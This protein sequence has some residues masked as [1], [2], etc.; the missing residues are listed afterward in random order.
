MFQE[1]SG[2]PDKYVDVDTPITPRL[3]SSERSHDQGCQMVY[4]LTKRPNLGKFWRALEWKRF[5]YIF[6]DHLECIT[7][8]WYILWPYGTLVAI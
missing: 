6:Y 7:A 5:V 3:S 8:V 2:N 1:K 4:F